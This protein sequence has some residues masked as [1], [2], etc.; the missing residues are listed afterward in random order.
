MHSRTF[1]RLKRKHAAAAQISF[2]QMARALGLIAGL[3]RHS[4][5]MALNEG[6]H[7]NKPEPLVRRL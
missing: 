4:S 6:D 3:G 5:A 1:E 2:Y 7:A